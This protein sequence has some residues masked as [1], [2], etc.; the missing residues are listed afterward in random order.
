MEVRGFRAV[1]SRSLEARRRGGRSTA[2]GPEACSGF[3]SLSECA[4]TLHAAQNL[5][6][7]IHD[8]QP[9]ANAKAEARRA[10]EQARSDLHAAP[11][12]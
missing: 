7:A 1:K 8:L 5:A 4:T 9:G 11:R 6:A 10:A 12:G 3:K 2:A